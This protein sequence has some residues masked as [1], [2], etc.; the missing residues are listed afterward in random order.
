[1]LLNFCRGN[2]ATIPNILGKHRS[3]SHPSR[4]QTSKPNSIKAPKANAN[5][6]FLIANVQKLRFYQ[7]K[8]L[9]MNRQRC[10][11]P[12]TFPTLN[13][14][15]KLKNQD[16]LSIHIRLGKTTFF[17]NLGL[18]IKSNRIRWPI[19][20][21]KKP[22]DWW[23]LH[24]S[25]VTRLKLTHFQLHT[26]GVPF[27]TAP[28]LPR[29]HTH[30]CVHAFQGHAQASPQWVVNP[31]EALTDLNMSIANINRININLV[32]KTNN[33]FGMMGIKPISLSNVVYKLIY[34]ILANQLK[35]ILPPN[36]LLKSK[37][38]PLWMANY[39]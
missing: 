7:N 1:M 4:N 8:R 24:L 13:Q 33:P 25:L 11:V 22:N 28:E 31:R 18:E 9:S 30:L 21:Y 14:T 20:L 37:F 16:F 3:R 27:F 12:N 2:L 17:L 29:P 36:Y 35:A 38:F 5:N 34:K 32:P 10:G 19:T 26:R 39:E 23:R 6:L 15:S